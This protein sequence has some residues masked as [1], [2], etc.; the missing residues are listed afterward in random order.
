MKKKV[1]LTSHNASLSGAPKLL[2]NLAEVIQKEMGFETDFLL[3][4]DGPLKPEFLAMGEVFLLNRE[5]KSLRD[6]IKNRIKNENSSIISRLNYDEYSFII[7]NTIIAGDLLHEIRIFYS[8]LILSYVHELNAIAT[9]LATEEQIKYL[10]KSTNIFLSPCKNSKNYLMDS[11]K[12]AE[13]KIHVFPYFI[14]EMP[15]VVVEN[16]TEKPN[17]TIGGCGSVDL[18]KG[19]DLFVQLAAIFKENYPEIPASFIWQGSYEHSLEYKLLLKDVNILGIEDSCSFRSHKQSSVEFYNSLDVFVLT[20]REDPYPLVVLE[21]ANL[22]VPAVCFHGSGGSPEFIEGNGKVVKYLNL[23][24]MA[25]AIAYYYHH[26][27]VR[28]EDGKKAHAKLKHL[29]Q[30]RKFIARKLSELI[31]APL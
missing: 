6:R 4:A 16:E 15:K 13:D 18:R 26:P 14:P 12:I 1:L 21:S 11:Y 10:I 20:S 22:S 30:D 24:E 27:E 25:A 9:S 31:E 17:F 8:G 2:L 5:N 7:A 29:H 28:L 23:T 3:Q 19:T